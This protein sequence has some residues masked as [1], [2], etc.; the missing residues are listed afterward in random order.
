VAGDAVMLAVIMLCYV[1][2]GVDVAVVMVLIDSGGGDVA[3]ISI[4]AG[5]VV[6]FGVGSGV[7][8]LGVAGVAGGGGVS[9]AGARD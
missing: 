5:G 8:I 2:F 6:V 7:G 9:R 3:G 1:G 4:S